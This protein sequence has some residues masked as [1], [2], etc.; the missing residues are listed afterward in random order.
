MS[1][2][3]AISAKGPGETS[4]HTEHKEFKMA[5]TYILVVD[6]WQKYCWQVAIVHTVIYVC[7]DA[8]WFTRCAWLSVDDPCLY[9]LTTFG[10]YHNNIP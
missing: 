2:V 4:S 8:S 7:G 10:S 3:Q 5:S 9:S 1:N 6:V